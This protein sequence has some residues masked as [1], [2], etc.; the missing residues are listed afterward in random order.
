MLLPPYTHTPQ[1]GHSAQLQSA[2]PVRKRRMKDEGWGGGRRADATVPPRAARAG[3]GW[4][5]GKGVTHT[6]TMVTPRQC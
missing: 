4:A 6:V 3:S 5:G 1:D 2:E